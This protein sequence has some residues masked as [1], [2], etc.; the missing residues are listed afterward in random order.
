MNR[1]LAKITLIAAAAAVPVTAS[2][3]AALEGHWENPK[4]SV[5]VSIGRAA[6][7][8]AAWSI[9]ASD[10]AKAMRAR[11]GRQLHRH[12]HPPGM[13]PGRGRHFKGRLR[14]QAQHPHAPADVRLASVPTRWPVKGCVASRHVPLQGTALD[15]DQLS[16]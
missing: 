7:I 13:Q 1:I 4:G 10:K 11:A 9:E 5:I 3:Q 6:R 16:I 12:P 14:P 8:I 2:A 15:P